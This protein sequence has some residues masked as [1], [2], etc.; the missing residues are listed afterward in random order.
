[1]RKSRQNYFVFLQVEQTTAAPPVLYLPALPYSRKPILPFQSTTFIRH[2][3]VFLPS[4]L[5]CITC[6]VGLFLLITK[7][8]TVFH[9]NVTCFARLSSSKLVSMRV[10]RWHATML[11]YT[12]SSHTVQ[13]YT[14]MYIQACILA[15]IHTYIGL[16]V[17]AYMCASIHTYMHIHT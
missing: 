10:Y 16:N 9:S 1:M 7:S 2:I 14:H 17:H 12:T 6:S 15:C 4:I 3:S 5:S 8:K 13:T 11:C